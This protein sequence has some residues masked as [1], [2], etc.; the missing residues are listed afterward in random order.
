MVSLAPLEKGWVNGDLRVAL[1]VQPKMALKMVHPSPEDVLS[2]LQQSRC[3][4]FPFTGYEPGPFPPASSTSMPRRWLNAFSWN[5][6][7][8]L[9]N[10]PAPMRNR[11]LV[12]TMRKTVS[13]AWA[14]ED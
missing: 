7:M 11:K 14:W 8:A 6:P 3:H 1:F 4:T 2:G 9:L 12:M 13:A 5:A 10:S